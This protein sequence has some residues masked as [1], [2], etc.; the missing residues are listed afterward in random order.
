MWTAPGEPPYNP[1]LAV[2]GL[3]TLNALNAR[4]L[5]IAFVSVSFNRIASRIVNADDGIMRAAVKLCVLDRSVTRVWFAISFERNGSTF[6]S[7]KSFFK[8]VFSQSAS[9]D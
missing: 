3:V 5:E 4:F 1:G 6:G 9:V 7:I 8:G 2:A